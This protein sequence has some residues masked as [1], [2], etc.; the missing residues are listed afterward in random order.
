MAL[1]IEQG[2]VSGEQLLQQHDPPGLF[3]GGGEGGSAAIRVV[4]EQAF[5]KCRLLPEQPGQR[6]RP[7]AI[8]VALPEQVALAVGVDSE[9]VVPAGSDLN[10]F[11]LGGTRT[12]A[13]GRFEL[14]G[15]LR[16]D[17][18][19]SGIDVIDTMLILDG[20]PATVLNSAGSSALA[21]TTTIAN[22]GCIELRG[23][24][25]FTTGGTFTVAPD[26][27]LVVEAGSV[28]EVPNV[29]MNRLTNFDGG[30]IS[31]GNFEVR[32]TLR[33]PNLA[34]T[35]IGVVGNPTNITLDGEEVVIVKAS[36]ILARIG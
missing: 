15:T 32:G 25:D 21:A 13:G 8:G 27:M 35:T 18:G 19:A 20:D 36:D 11:N 3:Y 14:K 30:V 31:D 4:V 9:F 17:A 24:K 7:H 22:N 33:A 16:F 26:G 5:D 23:G 10:G 34:V 28:F 29:G 2:L 12:L 6:A 1:G